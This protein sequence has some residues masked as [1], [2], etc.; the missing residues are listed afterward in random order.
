MRNP[1]SVLAVAAVLCL[2]A[3]PAR[4]QEKKKYEFVKPSPVAGLREIGPYQ[5]KDKKV[6]FPINVWGGWAPIVAAN[7]GF[8]ANPD[9]VFAKEFGFQV[10]LRVI[11]NPA[12]AMTVY[13]SGEAQILWGTVDMFALYA[14]I[15]A[16]DPRTAPKIY[17][18]IDFSNGGDGIVVRPGIKNAADLKGKEI[19]L[20][21]N[22]PSH[23][24]LLTVLKDAGLSPADV[25]L[26]FTSDAFGAADAFVAESRF[27]ACISWS[28]RI[29]EVVDPKMGG[30]PDGVKG[31]RLLT[32]TR[33]ASNLIAD[34]WAARADFAREHPEVIRGLVLGIFKG[35]DLVKKDPTVVAKLL[36]DG[37]GIPAEDCR[38][39]ML[40][41]HMTN[42]AENKRF[43]L[44]TSNPAN[45][46][47][48]WRSASEAYQSVRLVS[49]PV[50]PDQVRVWDVLSDANAAKMFA[51]HRDD[52]APKF[53]DPTKGGILAEREPIVIKK[54]ILQFRSGGNKLDDA[55]D[56]NIPKALEEIAEMAAR[57]GA[58]RVLVEG[59]ADTSMRA[60]FKDDPDILKQIGIGVKQLSEE[61]A[62]AVKQALI[63]KFGFD[64]NKFI[65]RGNGWD[66]PLVKDPKA[67]EDH[68]KNRRVEV[69]VLPLEGG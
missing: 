30:K 67:E 58:A 26:T 16:K 18:Q 32:T 34:V 12:D 48:L 62:A 6:V 42:F 24:Y 36:A 13:A 57:F 50:L 64:P 28:P 15:L 40:D 31:A 3:A 39:M 53:G 68:A 35:M 41:A 8:K 10:E 63:E 47:R 59:N 9:S 25:T 69:K 46:D 51:H 17:Q 23:F 20:T 7:G 21:Q 60:Q 5:W 11:D 61:R 19:V 55:Y 27:A 22:S 54:I 37:F 44:D 66:N 43:F 14:P 65:S 49:T 33:D 52:Y 1:R 29:Y 4:A 56:P 45:F 38:N 2:L